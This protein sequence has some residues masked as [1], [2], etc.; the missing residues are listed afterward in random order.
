MPSHSSAC[1]Q[2]DETHQVLCQ[3]T[4]LETPSQD[5]TEAVAKLD[6]MAH[7]LRAFLQDAQVIELPHLCDI[8]QNYTQARVDAQ[9]CMHGV[10]TVML[11]AVRAGCLSPWRFLPTSLPGLTKGMMQNAIPHGLSVM[12]WFAWSRRTQMCVSVASNPSGSNKDYSIAEVQYCLPKDIVTR[13][14]RLASLP[15]CHTLL[16]VCLD[17]I[18]LLCL[19]QQ[20]HQ[21]GCVIC[22]SSQ[23]LSMQCCAPPG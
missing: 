19:N 3:S 21:A 23:H 5:A 6:N 17:T 20:A 11:Q 7:R 18:C 14:V 2:V 12:H 4:K 15:P 16:M 13:R 8:Q 22:S 9:R 10:A 1:L